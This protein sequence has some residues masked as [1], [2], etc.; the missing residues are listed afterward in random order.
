M[1]VLITGGHF[2][3]AYAIIGEL[4]KHKHEIVIVGRKNP[5]EGDSHSVS[6]EYSVSQERSLPFYEL[7]TGRFQRKFTSRTMNS[8]GRIPKG[9]A[10][11]YALLGK[12]KPD[13]VLT[14]G[15]YIALPVA[16]AAKIRRIPIVTHEQTQGLGLSNTM[17]AKLA[18]SV[19]VSFPSTRKKISH[20]RV[21]L[22]GNPLRENIFNSIVSVNVEKNTPVLY[23][24]GGSTGAHRINRAVLAHLDMLLDRY[25]LI[26]QTGDN[27]FHDFQEI[28]GKREKLPAHKASRYIVKKFIFP[29]EIGDIYKKA[30]LVIGRSGANT[31]LELIALNKPAL[32]IPLPHGQSGEQRE[33]AELL[34]KIGI[35][36]IIDQAQIDSEDFVSTIDSM[37]KDLDSY[38]VSRDII[39]QYVFRDAAS[40]IVAE[41]NAQYEKKKS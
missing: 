17:I 23:I 8:I 3:P 22:T 18:D 26:H 12:I 5:F 16:I 29:D 33:N 30:D 20:K 41:L 11:A 35:G 13:V 39:E 32:L 38:T 6:Y 27:E 28:M 1:K 37:I 31:T 7:Q 25:T 19:C 21:V 36:K 10:Q 9:L 15:G 40:K 14:F 4:Q 34:E 2:S 24:T